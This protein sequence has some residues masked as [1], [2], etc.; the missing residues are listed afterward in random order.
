MAASGDGEQSHKAHRFRQAGPKKR[1]KSNKKNG[2]NNSEDNNNTPPKNPKAFGFRSNVKAKRLQSHAMEKEQRK[3]HV[4]KIDRN[5]GDAPPFVIVVHGPP[6]VGK[7]LLIKCLVKHYTKHNL[8]DVQG[9]VTIVSGKLRRLQFVE[10]PNDMNAMIDCAKFADLALLLVD[11]S[12]GFEMETFEF[13]NIMQVHGFPKVM[14]VLTHLDQFKDVKKLRKTKQRLKHRFWTEIYD[15][16]K[17]F[18]LSGLLHG[19]YLN[20]EIL[21]LS[22]FISVMKFHPLSWRTTHPYV[23]ADRFEDVTPPERVQMDKKCDRNVT[24]YGYLRG[25]N[26]KKGHKVHIAGVGDFN[27]AGVSSLADPC[28][29]PSAA[30]KKGLRDKEKLFYAPMSGVGDLVYDKDAVYININDNLV[31]FSEGAENGGFVRKGKF[32]VGE[33]MVK[34]L[35]KV[36]NPIDE[37]L[38]EGQLK[39]FSGKQDKHE[40]DVAAVEDEASGSDDES[41]DSDSGSDD[42]SD[43]SDSDSD[44]LESSDNEMDDKE[45]VKNK[46][47]EHVEFAN[48]RTR[49][50]AMFGDDDHASGEHSSD[51]GEDDEKND[52]DAE[53]GESDG[54]EGDD[55][56]PVAEI[57]GS[58]DSEDDEEDNDDGNASRWRESLLE[59]AASRQ[60]TNLMQ[61]VYGKSTSNLTNDIS[62]TQTSSDDESDKEFF[63][64]KGEGTKKMTDD[65]GAGNVDSDDCSKFA[66]I[67]NFK[68]WHDDR[69]V[70]S[71]RDRFVTGDWSKAAQRA[72]ASEA[73]SDNDDEDGAYGDFEDVEAGENEGRNLTG[74]GGTL[75]KEDDAEVEERKLKKLALRA[76]FDA[77]YD[78]SGLPDEDMDEESEPKSDHNKPSEVDHHEKL[79]K[80]IE[81]RQ[82]MNLLEL[83]DLDEEM[84][85]EIEGFK[86]GTYVRLEIHAV[87]YEMVEYFDPQYPILVG[88]ISLAEENIGYMQARIKRHRWHKKVLKTRDPI[89]LSMGWR[90]YQ[91]IPVY[92]IE[93]SNSRLRMLKYTPEHMHCLAMFYGPLAPPNTGVVAIQNLSN[94]QASFRITATAVVLEFN[95]AAQ[96][97]KKIKLTGYPCKIFKKTAYIKDMFTSDLEIARYEGASVRTASGIRGRVKKAANELIGQKAKGKDGNTLDGGVARC[98]FEDKILM[99]DIVF[100]KGWVSVDIPKFFNPLT[101]ALQPRDHVWQG[102]KTVGE[103]RRERNLPVPVN[104]DSQYKPIERKVRKFNPLVIPK[105][106]QQAL[107]FASKPKDMP[108]KR[109]ARW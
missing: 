63:R 38:Q 86:T 36:T 75:K 74:E 24:V 96:I 71:I 40:A 66:S 27:L 14:G 50:K 32:D 77:Q 9:P 35:Q 1:V 69:N 52:S 64:P 93:D 84:R 107:P 102:M 49:R 87:P 12:Y 56:G 39:L 108:K 4:P 6:K 46:V 94:N 58:D 48:G 60:N 88:G 78:G 55:D 72:R 20:R 61:L 28:P 16:A 47:K 44:S 80:E 70:A 19:K 37:Q 82:Q 83:N 89:I 95:H 79:K 90:R 31:Q 30:K 62:E 42:E 22:R 18:Y 23:L 109:Q 51:D 13:L 7:S 15:G 81:I 105:S 73:G 65:E 57:S 29:L 76:K 10:C 98:T 103:L 21:N 92:A 59:R 45:K 43:D 33:E 67:L 100:L 34:S 85:I 3:L 104:K 53:D 5:I 41:D 11:G 97:K 101:T 54:S 25:C 17:L 26:L 68:N 91:T 106:L 8:P 2:V 99:S